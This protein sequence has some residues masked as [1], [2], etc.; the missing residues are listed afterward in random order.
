M[1]FD[2]L[3][4][5]KRVKHILTSYLKNKV[6][7]YSMIF[8]GPGA[9][10]LTIF[11]VAFAKAINCLNSEADFCGECS[12]CS[13]VDRDIF[14]DLKI[15]A[16]DGQQYKKEQILFLVEDNYKK[17]LRGKKKINILTEAHKMNEYSANAFLKVLE[18]PASDNIFILLTTNLNGLLPTIKSRCQLLKFAILSR[19]EIKDHLIEKGHDP[20]K[21][22]LMSYLC[23]SN[24]ESVL[25]GDFDEYMGQR[26]RVLNDL[27]KLIT[28]VGVEDI[29]LDFYRRSRS[30]EKFIAYFRWLV[31]LI[32][33]MLRD[34]MILKIDENSKNIINI[35]YK[36]NL[37]NLSKYI[38][39]EKVLFLIRKMEFLLRDIRRNLNTKVLILE[40]IKS[41]TSK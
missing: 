37:M 17:P 20:E 4:G 38:A 28:G 7:P 30:R 11:A 29:L 12:H 31:N 3:F 21:A 27:N 25:S 1:P 18:E 16:P 8:T 5:N 33:I 9:E 32:S 41:Y 34:I 40:F 2:D 19:D 36:E 10:D 39:I 15:L 26:A 14:L 35:D 24:I 22:G 13:E 23:Q 6:I